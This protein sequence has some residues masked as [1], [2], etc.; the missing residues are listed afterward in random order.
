MPKQGTRNRFTE[1][2]DKTP[3][4]VQGTL[5]SFKNVD[6]FFD[7]FKNIT[8]TNKKINGGGGSYQDILDNV[9]EGIDDK[10]RVGDSGWLGD[11]V[12]QSRQDALER[13]R[14]QNMPDFNE[15]YKNNI[16][17]RVQD[18]LRNSSADLE[19]PVMKYNDLGLGT[20]DFNKA[21]M[22]LIPLNKYYS[23]E[24]QDYVEAQL[25][26]T[27]KEGDRYKYRMITN[28][29]PVALVPSVLPSSNKEAV[30]K[31]YKEIYN[32]ANPF[33]TLRKYDLRIGGQ[34]AFT[35][36][37]KKS[38]ILKEKFPKP[39]NAVRIFVKVGESA[40]FQWPEYKW[41]GYAAIGIAELL[42]TL[43]Y[44]TSIIGVTG[45]GNRINIK[46][47]LENGVRF[48]GINLKRFEETLN[49]DSL[50]YFASDPS[51]LRTKMFECFVKQA[52]YYDDNIT[53]GLG[54]PASKD[55]I[56][57][58]VFNEYGRRDKLF[59]DSGKRNDNSQ[60]LYYIL[61]D[62]YSVE[63]LNEAILEIALDVVNKNREARERIFG[64]SEN[65]Q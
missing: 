59:N 45:C 22:G 4:M 58:I 44:A 24:Q 52:E 55:E 35:S 23:F 15:V 50:L 12:P 51:F 42:D 18:I 36:T 20:F 64:Q 53:T 38:Y 2:P 40:G 57:S 49:K 60:F 6:A 3:R 7:F 27:Y 62:I 61:S 10:I 34:D 63:D 48:W 8:V 17:P 13:D 28:G 47:Q 37:I 31:A 39:K 14:F 56:E 16:A 21:S 32:G 33:E 11:P 29:S 25:V 43:G 30:E 65:I 19:V 41:C 26:E 54:R 46:N 5:R 9:N 1:T